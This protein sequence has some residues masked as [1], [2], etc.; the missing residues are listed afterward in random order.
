MFA[1]EHQALDLSEEDVALLRS[2]LR[3]IAHHSERTHDRAR[4]HAV[5]Q[6]DH[7]APFPSHA[8]AITPEDV[9]SDA[10]ADIPEELASHQPIAVVELQ[11]PGTAQTQRAQRPLSNRRL[12]AANAASAA[13]PLTRTQQRTPS[14][15][16]LYVPPPPAH[17]R[18]L[19]GAGSSYSTHSTST[20][21]AIAGAIPEQSALEL[22]MQPTAEPSMLSQLQAHQARLPERKA[23]ELGSLVNKLAAA[24]AQGA[25]AQ[26][27]VM[28]AL[29]APQPETA[30]APEQRNGAPSFLRRGK[31]ALRLPRG[32]DSQRLGGK[33]TSEGPQHVWR[34]RFLDHHG[35]AR[36]IGLS[37]IALFDK[38][39][40]R[41]GV[42]VLQSG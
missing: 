40:Q 4:E 20:Q 19:A 8:V 24:D 13:M 9:D 41:C 37:G 35:D 36:L 7:R 12:G 23:S 6:P 17:L 30:A 39:Q 5:S 18:G 16:L 33:K 38:A 32:L 28:E 1:G 2:S 25:N 31:D 11:Q 27:I 10:S 42:A 34:L 15:A 3:D 22:P 26:Q 21:P 29:Q 14:G